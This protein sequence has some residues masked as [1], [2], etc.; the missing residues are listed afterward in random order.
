MVIMDRN[1]DVETG[2]DLKALVGGDSD[3]EGVSAHL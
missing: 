3:K 1:N 2:R